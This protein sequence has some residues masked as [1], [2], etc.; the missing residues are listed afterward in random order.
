MLRPG[1]VMVSRAGERIARSH[2][3]CCGEQLNAHQ[4]VS[5]GVCDR[6]RCQEWKIEQAG[7]ALLQ[8][9]RQ[10]L[11]DRLFGDAAAEVEAA[12]AGIGAGREALRATLPSQAKPL[13]PQDPDRRAAFEGH[14]R[15][16]VAEAFG[17]PV[18]DAE[19]DG[20]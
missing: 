8:R 15:R 1:S 7:A 9:R 14:L 3:G 17:S 5:S 13:A 10:E 11:K 2:C 18:P 20:R 12:A 4:A 6:P 19:E 16:I